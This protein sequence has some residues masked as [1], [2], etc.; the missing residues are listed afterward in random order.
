MPTKQ[1]TAGSSLLHSTATKGPH[2]LFS[3]SRENR[4]LT[5]RAYLEV[6]AR[7]LMTLGED[8]QRIFLYL[9]KYRSKLGKNREGLLGAE[10]VSDDTRSIPERSQSRTTQNKCFLKE[11]QSCEVRAESLKQ[12]A[13]DQRVPRAD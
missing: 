13:D 9:G 7:I 3:K 10:F 2:H 4:L 1:C 5:R 6:H 8:H 11:R 12:D